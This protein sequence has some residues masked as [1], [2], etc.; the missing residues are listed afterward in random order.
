[1]SGAALNVTPR[2][3]SPGD[4]L[5]HLRIGKQPF[6]NF[7]VLKRKFDQT[8]LWECAKTILLP[9]STSSFE[10]FPLYPQET[11]VWSRQQ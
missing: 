5:F 3:P 2:M 11:A 8:M 7:S 4:F 9:R 6:G 1:M 10:L